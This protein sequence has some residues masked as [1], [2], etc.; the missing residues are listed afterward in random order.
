MGES[1][2]EERDRALQKLNEMGVAYEMEEHPAVYTIEEMEILGIGARGTVV[3][4]LFLRDANGKRHFLVI[5]AP[6]KQ[7]DLKSIRAQIGSSALSF[8]SEER[9]QRLMKL[10]KGA[11]SP[12]GVLNDATQSVEV[13]YDGDLAGNPRLGVHPNDN[14]ATL[15]LSFEALERV[16]RQNG[17]SMRV[18]KI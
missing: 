7:A 18:I 6:E 13:L 2:M 17:N 11:V 8:A 1:E 4:N 14:T 10:T 3:K 12:L 5:L 9:L 15:W 16:I